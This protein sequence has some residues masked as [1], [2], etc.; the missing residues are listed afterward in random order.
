MRISGTIL[1]NDQVLMPNVNVHELGTNN[2]TRTNKDGKFTINVA[3]NKSQLKLTHIG[4]D[5][6]TVPAIDF[7]KKSTYEM[8]L[9]DDDLP[10]VI[11]PIKPKTKNTITSNYW[12]FV[13]ITVGIGYAVVK[14]KD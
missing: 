4:Y 11:I 9:S 5:Y 14:L 10:E 3:S 7:L 12:L 6:D 13:F 8:Y 2:S 1:T